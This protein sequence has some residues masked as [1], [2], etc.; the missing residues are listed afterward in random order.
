MFVSQQYCWHMMIESEG[1][2]LWQKNS[3]RDVAAPFSCYFQLDMDE[4]SFLFYKG[5][6][7]I[8]GR[9]DNLRHENNSVT[10]VF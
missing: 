2:D 9:K 8:L 1:D 5:E 3:P 4:T 6:L 7:K 10:Q